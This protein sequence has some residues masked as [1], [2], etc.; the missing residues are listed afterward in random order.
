MLKNLLL[1]SVV[2]LCALA[3]SPGVAN[4]NQV[5]W[6]CAYDMSYTVP[7][8][9]TENTFDRC[10]AVVLSALEKSGCQLDA[11]TLKRD[12]RPGL[13]NIEMHF[14]V[15]STNCSNHAL[16][17]LPT[18]SGS[19]LVLTAICAD[20][21]ELKSTELAPDSRPAFGR[22]GEKFVCVQK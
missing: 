11:S 22:F 10:D 8:A 2:T 14:S 19:S 13:L 16:K 1:S 21:S 7:F 4:A 9:S 5:N 17:M 15:A 18:G 3:L 12:F 20:G 6:F